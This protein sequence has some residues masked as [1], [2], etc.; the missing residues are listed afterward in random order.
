MS[1]S[2]KKSNNNVS[3]PDIDSDLPPRHPPI[4][5][6]QNATWDEESMRIE[7]ERVK[8]LLQGMGIDHNYNHGGR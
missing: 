7:S 1:I 5:I 3:I 6:R 8:Q 4:L 2:P